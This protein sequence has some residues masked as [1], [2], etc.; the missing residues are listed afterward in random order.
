MSEAFDPDRCF[1][2]RF[3]NSS[4]SKFQTFRDL[5]KPVFPAEFSKC[6]YLKAGCRKSNSNDFR[7]EFVG[8]VAQ[9]NLRSI[10]NLVLIRKCQPVIDNPPIPQPSVFVDRARAFPGVGELPRFHGVHDFLH[11]RGRNLSRWG[12]I[13]IGGDGCPP[14][15]GVFAI[16]PQAGVLGVK[17]ALRNVGDYI[18][19]N[20]SA[21]GRHILHN[22]F[23][24]VACLDRFF[25]LGEVRGLE[26]REHPDSAGKC[27]VGMMGVNGVMLVRGVAGQLHAEVRVNAGLGEPACERVA[28]RV[29]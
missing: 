21:I 27:L 20:A 6:R 23:D 28:E 18:R 16:L 14:M 11:D 17:N 5:L 7:G 24:N 19:G 1:T 3:R 9:A 29:E 13:L 2:V 26:F 12:G 8:Q 15:A 25:H 22:K 4:S 10:K